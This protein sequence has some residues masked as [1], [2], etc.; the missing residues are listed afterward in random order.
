MRESTL[1]SLLLKRV[2][3]SPDLYAVGWIETGEVKNMSFSNYKL[4]IEHVSLG[5]IKNGLSV[6]DKVAILGQTSKEWHFCDLAVMCS[7]SVVVPVYPTYLGNEITHI[8]NHSGSSVLIVENDNQM[9]KLTPHLNELK[10]IKLIVSLTELNEETKK[11]FRNFIKYTTYKELIK[12][13]AEFQ[14]SNPDKFVDLIKN[15]KPEEIA[16]IIYT[17]GTTGEPKGAVITHHAFTAMLDNVQNFIKGAFTSND[18]SLTFLPLSHVLGRCDSLLPL[19]FGWQSVYAEGI[20]KVAD[21]LQ[22]VQ[23]TIMLAVP[24]IFEK[25]FQKINEQVSLSPLWKQQA[26]KLALHTAELY[27]NKID[28]DRSPSAGELL[29]YR[30]SQKVIFQQIYQK[31]G[32]KIR[33]FVSGGAP[34]SPDII[35]FLRYA[36]LT[37]LEGYGLTET[38]APCS[39]N[40]LS[41][42][43]PGTVGKP[44]GDVEFRFAEDG[45]I[46]IKSAAMFKEYYNNPEATKES[47]TDEGWFKSGDI[48]HFNSE[49]YLKI[50]DRK[51]DIIITSGGKNVAPQKIENMLKSQKWISQAVVIGDQRKYLTAVIGIEKERFFNSLETIGLSADC[52]IEELSNH[53]WVQERI[54][55]DINAVNQGLAQYESIKKFAIAPQEFTT[56]NFLTPSLKIKRKAVNIELNDLIESLY[57]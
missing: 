42:Q 22:L 45:E 16:S 56:Q 5:L 50:T 26:F 3:L 39:L 55:E 25:I 7:R 11:K 28:A 20:D 31:F 1:G 37:V 18:K 19:I 40:P 35:K 57:S 2:S 8:I 34:L 9:E 53:P 27:F 52:S 12:D 14:R 23:P 47:F 36:N 41:R 44:I 21:N 54:N 38:I 30:A 10:D 17:S 4:A 43:V 29:A 15:L 13:G 48:G 24:R 46:L 32:G 33:F 51:K 6:G 49:G